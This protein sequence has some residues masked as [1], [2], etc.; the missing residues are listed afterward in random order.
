MGVL[1][2][3]L[4]GYLAN[5]MTSDRCSPYLFTLGP[6]STF[7]L[8]CLL[9]HLYL[10]FYSAKFLISLLDNVICMWLGEEIS[11]PTACFL[12][13]NPQVVHLDT[14]NQLIRNA[15]SIIFSISFL[16][17]R[18]WKVKNIISHFF[19]CKDHQVTHF[20]MAKQ[21]VKSNRGLLNK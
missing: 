1:C 13:P 11:L 3:L 14:M 2:K 19:L 8:Y 5:E 4:L 9:F 12:I 6:H 17:Y 7:P 21:E 16:C 18:D 20:C 10:P 15:V